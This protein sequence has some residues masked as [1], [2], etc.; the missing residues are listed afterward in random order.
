MFPNCAGW[1]NFLRASGARGL[2]FQIYSL[3]AN[4]G[5]ALIYLLPTADAVRM[6]STNVICCDWHADVA[7]VS[8]V[9]D[10]RFAGFALTG[11]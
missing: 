9:K 1:A 11:R 8:T 7:Y 3:V 10:S 5:A 4:S 6:N 2:Q